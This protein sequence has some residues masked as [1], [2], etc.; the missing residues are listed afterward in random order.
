MN[1]EPMQKLELKPAESGVRPE[2]IVLTIT[3]IRLH[4][5][6]RSPK[7]LGNFF[8]RLI[9]GKKPARLYF[10]LPPQEQNQNSIFNF[11][12]DLGLN[13]PVLLE[14]IKEYN[15]QG[16][17]VLISVPNDMLIFLG[18]DIAE[19]GNGIKGKRVVRRLMK[20]EN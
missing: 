13:D 16:R 1:Q 2:D 19:F 17:R 9:F 4:S 6:A 7:S 12:I 5:K 14:T 20:N 15:K 3:D 10:P 8:K 11:N 18:K